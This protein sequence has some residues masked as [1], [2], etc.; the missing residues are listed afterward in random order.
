MST[1]SAQ[2]SE[3]TPSRATSP[4]ATTRRRRGTISRHDVL[5]AA[6][7][8]VD[9]EG[10]DVLSM[11]KLAGELDME[12]MS[13][14]KRVANK[15]DLLAGVAE[16]IWDEVAAAAPPTKNWAKWL[17]GLGQA[18]RATVRDHPHAVPLLVGI[19]VFPTGMLEVIATQLERS[20]PGW[21]ARPDAVSAVCTVCAFALG[22]AIAECSYCV[23][24]ATSTDDDP[25]AAERQRLRRI[26]RALPPDAPDRLVDTA[27]AV[28]GCDPDDTFRK[29]L[30]LIVRG[31]EPEHR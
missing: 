8:V 24:C 7:A 19:E 11:R 6:L 14:Y 27:M 21:P 31:C 20:S 5:V 23:D 3:V 4:P 2:K 13:L 1:V 28:C 29:G 16:L 9:R 30:D 25:I 18:I 12:T 17:R 15:E 10:L 26:A 22:C